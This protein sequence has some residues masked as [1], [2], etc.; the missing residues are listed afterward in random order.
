MRKINKTSE[1]LWVMGIV[2]VAFGVAV[3]S[4]AN[5]G[6]SMIAAPTF[7]IQEAIAPLWSGFTV[8]VTEYLVQAAVLVLMCIIVRKVNW[9]YLLAFAAAVI[10]GYAL[11]FAIWV[12]G[13]APATA[14]W[15][16][17]LYLLMGDVLVGA[18]V[19]CFFRT[20]MPLQVYE[21]FVA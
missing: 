15:Q 9:R 17:W 14:P 12:V 21:L 10:Y 3:C 8:G 18:G 20:Y 13:D 1:L 6:V 16:C 7:I 4:K 19:A 11:D 5:L 2:L